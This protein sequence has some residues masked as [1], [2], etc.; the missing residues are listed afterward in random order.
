MLYSANKCTF[1]VNV[2]MCTTTD[3][4][5][6]FKLGHFFYCYLAL[7]LKK[8]GYLSTSSINTT[9][10]SIC[11]TGEYHQQ[12]ALPSE[13][14]YGLMAS[15]LFFASVRPPCMV[16]IATSSTGRIFSCSLVHARIHRCII[17]PCNE[18]REITA[19][20]NV[21]FLFFFNIQFYKLYA[22]SMKKMV[23][24]EMWIFFV[25]F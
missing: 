5:C 25:L 24:V 20:H 17:P 6:L 15:S 8:N 10:F 12:S 4:H 1:N 22:Q 3:W 18:N 14:V 19:I 11:L 9:L 21:H 7:A 2:H 13:L 23:M 16:V